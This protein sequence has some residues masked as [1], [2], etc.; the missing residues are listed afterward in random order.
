MKRIFLLRHAKAVAKD[1]ASDID[2]V[3]AP[4]GRDQMG[5]IAQH[6]AE[7]RA[8]ADLAIVSPAARTRETWSLAKLAARS[9][10]FED[11]V[12]LPRNWLFGSGTVTLDVTVES[13]GDT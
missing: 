9:T 6:L 12:T 7:T 4:H 1:E 8:Q 2:R 10:R 13:G 5:R 11:R 3:L